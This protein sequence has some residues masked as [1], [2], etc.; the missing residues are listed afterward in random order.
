MGAGITGLPYSGEYSFAHTTMFWPQTHMVAPKSEALQCKACH[1]EGGRM[2]WEALGYPGDPIK[3]GSRA[4]AHQDEARRAAPAESGLVG[5]G[6]AGDV[7]AA[8]GR[9]KS[10][11]P[12]ATGAEK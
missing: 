12:D 3:W 11:D 4:R 8:H 7:V 6:L 2:D 1:A 5:A 10:L 9:E